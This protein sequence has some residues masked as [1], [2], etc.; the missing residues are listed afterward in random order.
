[1]NDKFKLYIRFLNLSLGRER[2][3]PQQIEKTTNWE[4]I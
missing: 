3:K 2:K 1:M 4:K